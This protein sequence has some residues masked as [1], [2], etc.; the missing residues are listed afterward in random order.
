MF[1][2]EARSIAEEDDDWDDFDDGPE[3]IY[4]YGDAEDGDDDDLE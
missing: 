4:A 3:I 1:A 2:F